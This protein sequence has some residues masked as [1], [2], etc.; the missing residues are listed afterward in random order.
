MLYPLLIQQN[1][2][3]FLI[4][5]LS[6]GR[7]TRMPQVTVHNRFRRFFEDELEPLLNSPGSLRLLADPDSSETMNRRS[8]TKYSEVTIAIGPEGGWNDFEIDLI[9]KCGFKSFLLGNSIL[10]VES[11]VTAA[12]AQLEMLRISADLE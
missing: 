7:R 5:G 1:I 10:R 12:L 8:P 9:I 6:Q 11:A 2:D 3:K 4:D